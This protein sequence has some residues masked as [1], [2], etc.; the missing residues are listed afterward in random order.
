MATTTI[1]I[2][3]S[4]A[5]LTSD[6]LSISKTFNLT[7]SSGTGLTQTTGLNRLNNLSST[8]VSAR[9]DYSN[10]EGYFFICNTDTTKANTVT[11]T[12]SDAASVDT[13]S[14]LQGGDSMFMA[15]DVSDYSITLT[16]SSATSTVEYQIFHNG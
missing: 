3:M 6:A 4:S 10:T 1:K 14:I 8:V 13:V 9:A 12:F 11:I 15:V 16:A 2:T 5:D 7:D